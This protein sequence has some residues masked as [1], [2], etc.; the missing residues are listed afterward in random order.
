MQGFEYESVTRLVFGTGALARLGGL[1]AELGAGQVLVVT[2]P[3]IAA[4]GILDRA[5]ESLAAAG[6]QYAVFDGVEQNPGSRHVET[7]RRFAE[8]LPRPA[9]FVVALG[10]GSAMDC[11]KG[12]NFLLT[13]GGRIEEYRGDGKAKKPLLPAIGVPTTAGTGSEAQR[14]A[15]IGEAE[16]RMK[17]A[18]GDRTAR[19]R[20]ALLDPELT[21]TA[22]REVAAAAAADAISHAVESFASANGNEVSRMFAGRALQLLAANLRESLRAGSVAARAG[23]LLG[24]HW[25]GAAIENSMLG[26]A[27]A[28]ANPLTARYGIIHGVAVGVML[29][30]VIRFNGAAVDGSYTE[31]ARAVGLEGAG[32]EALAECVRCWN[33]EADL[34]ERLRDLDVEAA[35]L[36]GLA[37]EAAAQRTARFNPRPAG[38]R[39]LA[40]LYEA[41]F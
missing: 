41:A 33:A 14:F 28:C 18:I 16:S 35:S 40:G 22:P 11:A 20:V 25:A 6:L 27:H 17:M 23:M 7:G 13:N 30:H 5:T 3:G 37:R 29:P 36:P 21:A 9:D 39:E 2:D 4:A 8:E 10:G 38:E 34:P 26:A 19:F 32:A 24:A 12:I 15:L 1:A 31:L